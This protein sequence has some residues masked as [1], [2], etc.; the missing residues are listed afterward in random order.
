MANVLWFGKL[1]SAVY[2]ATDG[3]LGHW[4]WH[5][6]V[7]MHTIGAKSRAL[8]SVTVQYYPV[9]AEG[10]V[11]IPSNNGQSRP[12]A[13]WFNLQ[14]NP[15]ITIQIGRDQL[16]VRAEVLGD[17]EHARCWDLM[18][19]VNPQIDHYVELSGRHIPAVLL[20]RLS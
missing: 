11:V 15:D 19:Q 12:P 4:L 8:R 16:R 20:R 18:R 14:A 3:R 5:R 10:V 7:L 1:H 2:Q 17:K 13:W 6:M 9:H